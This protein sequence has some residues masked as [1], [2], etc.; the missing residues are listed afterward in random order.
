MII[1]AANMLLGPEFL[2]KIQNL[3][4]AHKRLLGSAKSLSMNH[5]KAYISNCNILQGPQFSAKEKRD[6][7][8]IEKWPE[9]VDFVC[10]QEV[11]DRISAITLMYEMR[12][13]FSYFLKVPG[14][15]EYFWL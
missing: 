1:F 8:I 3:P 15:K 10:L 11:W 14:A 9:N 6:S 13:K 4:Y 7:A 5:A 12:N 2:G